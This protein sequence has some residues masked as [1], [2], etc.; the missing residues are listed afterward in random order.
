LT[1]LL[2]G[3]LVGLAYHFEAIFGVGLLNL[4]NWFVLTANNCL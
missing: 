2:V 1:P 3:F 4:L